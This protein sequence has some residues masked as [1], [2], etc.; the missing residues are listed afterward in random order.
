MVKRRENTMPVI[1]FQGDS[2][3]DCE[4]SRQNDTNNGNGYPALVSSKL[5]FAYPGGHLFLNRGV[6]GDRIVDL[7]ARIKSDFINLK[8]DI[9]S[10]LIGVNDVWHELS[11]ENGVDAAKFEMIYSM[12]VEEILDALP[13]VQIMILEPFVLKASATEGDYGIFR[14]EVEKRAAASKRVAQKHELSFIPLQKHFDK[15]AK[16]APASC[17]L[18]DGVHPTPA[19]HELISKEWIKMFEAIK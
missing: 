15:A 10:I 9:I 12:L 14:Q 18:S 5:G 11:R 19:G 7:Y 6:S 4:R 16:R 3:T 13:L 2:I 1:L 8:P 17:W